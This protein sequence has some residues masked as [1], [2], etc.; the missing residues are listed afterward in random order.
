MWIKLFSYYGEVFVW[1]VKLPEVKKGVLFTSWVIWTLVIW[2]LVMLF[3]CPPFVG[4]LHCLFH[5][6]LNL[7]HAWGVR[8]TKQCTC[9]YPILTNCY[10]TCVPCC[11]KHTEFSLEFIHTM[12]VGIF[13]MMYLTV[14]VLIDNM[15]CFYDSKLKKKILIKKHLFGM[16]HRS[17]HSVNILLTYGCHFV[18]CPLR[19]IPSVYYE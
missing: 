13:Y 15:S 5:C 14:I 1:K 16:H 8:Q 11:F 18:W 17:K 3:D 7:T 10:T 12:F 9:F 19:E 6:G 4:V 2:T